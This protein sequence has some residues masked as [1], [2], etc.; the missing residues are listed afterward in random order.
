M[1]WQEIRKQYPRQWVVVEAIRES[2][3]SDLPGIGAH[4]LG[5]VP[6]RVIDLGFLNA[7]RDA[8]SAHEGFLKRKSQSPNREFYVV[9]TDVQKLDID[10]SQWGGARLW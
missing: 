2:S 9:H 7:Y 1:E 4:T 3:K 10:E 6:S 8:K 5:L